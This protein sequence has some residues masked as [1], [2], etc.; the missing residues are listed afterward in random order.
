MNTLLTVHFSIFFPIPNSEKEENWITSYTFTAEKEANLQ[1]VPKPKM[2]IED[3]PLRL[4]VSQ[5]DPCISGPQFHVY[6]RPYY[7]R[8]GP[9]PVYITE[10][11][12]FSL[13]PHYVF[14]PDP[15]YLQEY[16]WW[17]QCQSLGWEMKQESNTIRL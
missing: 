5:V 2:W 17:T 16:D 3:G 4:W 7:D 6:G 14:D 12:K 8:M 11:G 15:T 10:T 13:F 1:V 9:R